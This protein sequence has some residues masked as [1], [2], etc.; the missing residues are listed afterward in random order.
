M[1]PS[2]RTLR[3]V[4][5]KSSLRGY[6][7]AEVDAYLERVAV[8]LDEGRAGR[9]G[10]V[11]GHSITQV[12]FNASFRGYNVDQVDAYLSDLAAALDRL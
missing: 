4:R 3:E 8:A 5:F 2:G 12:E 9:V 6:D 11:S 7:T 1:E 10:E